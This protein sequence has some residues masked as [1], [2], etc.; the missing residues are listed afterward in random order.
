MEK[1]L[2][3]L[4]KSPLFA[5]IDDQDVLSELG[6]L[7]ARVREFPKGSFVFTA[8]DSISDMALVLEGCVHIVQDDLWG[9]RSILS[10]CLPGD[11]FGEVYASKPGSVLNVSAQAAE[12]SRIMLLD[13]GK[14][15]T[16]CSSACSHHQR[17]ISNLV[18]VLAGKLLVFNDKVT[19]ISRRS[20]R[21]KLLSYL[22]A[23]AQKAGSKAFDIPFDRQQ[24]ADY[25]CVD[26]AAMSVELSKL[27]KEGV[28]T[29]S[30]RHFE[31]T[32]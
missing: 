31:L 7:G 15:L 8:G 9:R 17:L 32:K 21:E 10:S 23:Q 13:I 25:L 26:R 29:T 4:K 14:V 27:Q 24:L 3:V 20:T 30:R 6:C 1:Y 19:H 12:D 5:G 2:P 28:L 16:S 11:F 22:S 18:G